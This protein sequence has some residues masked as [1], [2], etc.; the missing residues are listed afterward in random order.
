MNTSKAEI[1]DG[2]VERLGLDAETIE[3][4]L[5]EYI[6]DSELHIGMLGTAIDNETI[7]DIAHEAHYVKGSARN[8]GIDV[9]SSKAEIIEHAARHGEDVPYKELFEELKNIFFN[10]KSVLS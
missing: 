4:L 10:V 1:I 7:S 2:I 8:F 3:M 5:G 9:I 6:E